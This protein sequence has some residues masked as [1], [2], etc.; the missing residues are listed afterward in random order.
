[1]NAIETEYKGYLFRSRLEARWAVFF[2]AAGIEW[3]YESE[4]YEVGGHRYLPD[5]WL[6]GCEVF[7]EV[8]GDPDGLR[9]D[10][11]RMCAVLGPRS[12][13]PGFADGKHGLLVLGDIPEP[14]SGAV[15]LHP[16]LSRFDG[17]LART[18][19]FFVPLKDGKVQLLVDRHQS[20]M[21]LLFRKYAWGDPMESADSIAWSPE[22][23]VMEC[24]GGFPQLDN[25]YR[26]AR[27]ARFE[28]GA[29]GAGRNG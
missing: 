24:P 12:P 14:R 28:H 9:K 7:V 27:Q 18:F 20:F 4:G 2:D 21:S 19:A 16:C 25:A 13:L 11:A 5:F 10:H 29:Q 26:A 22:P 6:P 1:M 17:I 3:K 8:K 15:I 23:W